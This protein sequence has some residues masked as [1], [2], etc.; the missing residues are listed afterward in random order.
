[1]LETNEMKFTRSFQAPCLLAAAFLPL[2]GSMAGAA[3]V[4]F[5]SETDFSNHFNRLRGGAATYNSSGKFIS[6]SENNN[7]NLYAYDLNG[8][9]EGVST[10][11]LPLGGSLTVSSDVRFSV[12]GPNPSNS[13]SFGIF[14]G[15]YLALLNVANVTDRLRLGT[16]LSLSDGGVG[17]FAGAEVAGDVVPVQ[18]DSD[19]VTVTATMTA[20]TTTSFVFSLKVGSLT[21][22]E[23]INAALPTD[24]QLGLRAYN[25]TDSGNRIDIDNFSVDVVPEPSST[26][27]ISGALSV[28]ALRRRRIA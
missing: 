27:L 25:V 4:S 8:S 10:F 26:M 1:M 19:W 14:F 9:E 12:G 13:S 28:I 22:T 11:S 18:L 3:V 20:V 16:N 15:N 17:N 23:T 7:T 24:F 2:F 5:D 21:K 6:Y